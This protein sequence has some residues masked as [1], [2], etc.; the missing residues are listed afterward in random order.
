VA[1]KVDSRILKKIERGIKSLNVPEKY[2]KTAISNIK[3]WLS[4]KGFH[5]YRDQIVFLIK[6]KEFELLLN[7]FYQ[8]MPFG[9]GGRRGPVGIGPNRIN[10]YTIK[11][12]AQGHAEYLLKM[13]PDA[14][15]RGVVMSGSTLTQVFTPKNYQIL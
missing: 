1:G 9:T 3:R 12:S 4:E 11:A 15:K 14:K 13:H 10:P 8:V 6:N 2:K 7:S 5:D